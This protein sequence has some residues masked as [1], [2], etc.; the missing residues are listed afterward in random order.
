M[1]ILDNIAADWR[2]LK[3]TVRALRLVSPITKHPTR[4]FPVAVAELAEKHG[5]RP[6]LESADETFSYAALDAR[7]N[8]WARWGRAQGLGKGDVVALL[9]KN[10]PEFMALWIGLNRIGAVVALLNTNLTGHL[11]AHSIAIV[12]PKHVIAAADLAEALSD[13]P[14]ADGCRYWLHG[15]AEGAS[16]PRVDGEVDALPTAPVPAAELPPVTIDDRALLIYTSGTTGMPKAANVNHFRVMAMASSFCG[17]MNVKPRD[18]MY[19][20]L[21]MY[22]AAGGVVAAG[23]TLIGGGTVVIR[24]RFSALGFW[25]DI[26]RERCTLFQYIGELCRYLVNAPET[27]AEKQHHLRLVCGNGLRPDIWMRF[28]D[29]F[30][31]PEILE[32]YSATE[33]NVALYNFDGRPGS[34]GRIPWWLEHRLVVRVVRFDIETEEPVRGPDGHCIVCQPGEVGEAIGEVVD[35][36]KKP[37]NRFAGYADKAQ[38]EKKTIQNVFKQGDRW[39]RTGDLMRQ[40]E[41]GYFYFVDRIGDTFR[42]KGENVATAQVA[43]TLNQFPGVSDATVYGVPVPGTEGKAGMAAIVA[44]DLDLSGLARYLDAELPVYARPVFLRL[45]T[46][47]EMTGTFKQRK[48]ELVR[49]GFDPDVIADPL[50]VRRGSGYLPLDAVLFRRIVTGEMR[51]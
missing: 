19:L 31:I 48:I 8:Q 28:K 49:D 4:T 50:F 41:R 18:R 15:E 34:I 22:H 51:V 10:R 3:S 35:D 39:F 21:P 20:C 14:A 11:L 43:E 16:W 24:E 36:P 9:M 13:V 42:W 32:F 38:G 33:G 37:A 23:A 1:Q 40:D 45:C 30:R 7:A 25:R 27:E 12:A 2:F 17:A 46:A 47:L 6:A 44:H 29:R 26:A 5:D